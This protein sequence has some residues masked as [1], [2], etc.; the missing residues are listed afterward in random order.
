MT[1]FLSFHSVFIVLLSCVQMIELGDSAKSRVKFD[2]IQPTISIRF[3][4]LEII[5]LL[6]DVAVLNPSETVVLKFCIF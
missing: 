4:L 3:T 6:A 1:W 5:N 2:S